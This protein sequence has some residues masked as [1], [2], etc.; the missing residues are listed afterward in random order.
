[1]GDNR[2]KSLRKLL[3]PQPYRSETA[4]AELVPTPAR[5]R[6]QLPVP[7]CFNNCA[8]TWEQRN[9]SG[10]TWEWARRPSCRGA[11]GH[12]ERV[13]IFS[14]RIAQALG[15]SAEISQRICRAAYMHDI[16]KIAVPQPILRKPGA[17]TDEERMAMQVHPLI[18][19]ELLGAFLPTENMAG[20]ALFAP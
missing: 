16:G 12:S 17:L 1:M 2:Q 20:S 19:R 14:V 18:S 5:P 7:R 13:A 9:N 8:V 6:I 11:S 3:G 15:L 4:A 10:E